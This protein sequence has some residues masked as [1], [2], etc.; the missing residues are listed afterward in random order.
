[1]NINK[2]IRTWS[3]INPMG[4]ADDI[5]YVGKTSSLGRYVLMENGGSDT[6]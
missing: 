2:S 3:L 5:D 4:Y 1:M 6:S